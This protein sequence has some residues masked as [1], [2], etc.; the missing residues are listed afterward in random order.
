[1]NRTLVAVVALAAL[2]SGTVIA[3]GAFTTGDEIAPA[4]DS[5]VYLSA[6]DT[7]N[8]HR[9]VEY[10][11]NGQI[12]LHLSPV[13]PN[14]RTR[15]NDLFVVGFA[16]YENSNNSTTV[17]LG[18]DSERITIHRMDTGERINGE[19]ILLQPNE[20]VLFG[21][22]VS[23]EDRDFTSEVTV[24][25]TVP[26][27][28]SNPDEDTDEDTDSDDDDDDDDTTDRNDDDTSSGDGDTSGQSDGGDTTGKTTTDTSPPDSGDGSTT[29]EQPP[30]A[31]DDTEQPVEPSGFIFGFTPVF[32][33]AWVWWFA[34]G[35][36]AAILANYLVQTRHH[37]VLPI[38]QMEES[39]RRRRLKDVLRGE[40]V[41]GLGV[42]VLSI[43]VALSLSSAGITG[44][45]QLIGTLLC[46]VLAG[47]ATGYRRLPD[48]RVTKRTADGDPLDPDHE[49]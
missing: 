16:G 37:G 42:V 32:G 29:D 38:F 7:E 9:Y 30:T 2:I 40:S 20:S 31:T 19:P 34:L 21:V 47:S 49:P 1:M 3:T 22:T 18:S 35:G 28:E 33:V 45:P 41:V 6:A 14:S 4:D 10:D 44:V 5:E 48:I 15:V 17:R 12:R 8:G 46:S 23:P 25:A 43:L 39:A 27:R 24:E 11:D 36:V 13:L 26:E